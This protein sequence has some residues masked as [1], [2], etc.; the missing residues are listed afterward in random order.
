M[1]T[2]FQSSRGASHR[3]VRTSAGA[4]KALPVAAFLLAAS[5][6]GPAGATGCGPAGSVAIDGGSVRNSTSIS[7]SADGGVAA[8]DASGGNG[9]VALSVRGVAAA[10]NGGVAASSANGGMIEF[11][12]IDS[13]DNAG[14]TISVAAS[15]SGCRVAASNVAIDG[16]S[17]RNETTIA[18]SADG[19]LAVSDASGGNRNAALSLGGIA[20]AG[21]GGRADA[22]A[23][24]GSIAIGGVRS[25]GNRGNVIDVSL[26]RGYFGG[27]SAVRIDGGTVRNTTTIAINADG[28]TALADASGGNRNAAIAVRGIALAGNGGIAN[29]SADGGAV[30]IGD[31]RSGNNRGNTIA[32]SGG[33]GAVAVNG[34]S[35]TNQTTIAVSA[36]GGTAISDA[37]GGDGNL[38]AAGPGGIAGAGNGGI[39][40]ASAD[41]GAVSIGDIDSGGNRGNEIYVAGGSG[42]VAIDG[43]SVS[44]QTTIDVSADGGTAVADA[45]GGNNN[46]AGAGAGGIAGAGNG[47]VANSSA[48]GGSISIGDIDSGNNSGNVIVV[49]A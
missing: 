9:N 36:D 32:V 22:D 44:N 7:V 21:N 2:I 25:G 43:G 15:G 35:V 49:G 6:A 14:N 1:M 24:G 10:G 12:T 26:H 5:Q 46:A 37:S 28:G 17:V 27:A 47:G 38:A 34:G 29:A 3:I 19:G 41:G 11:G 13:G 16:G 48:D 4:L 20:L 42:P 31:V 39:A 23:N 45:S 30:V 40:N 18:V 33:N 8:S